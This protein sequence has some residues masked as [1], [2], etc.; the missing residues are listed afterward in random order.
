MSMPRTGLC[1]RPRSRGESKC[2]YDANK[3]KATFDITFDEETELTGYMKLHLW[4]EAD[5]ND[6]M[7]LFVAIQKLDAKGKWLPYNVMGK[8]HPGCPGKLRVS[9]REVDE[10]HPAPQRV[11]AVASLQELAEAQAGRDRAG[12]DRDLSFEPDLARGRAV[13]RGGHGALRAHRLVRALR[14]E[15]HQQGQS[16]HSLGR[17]ERRLGTGVSAGY[18]SDTSAVGVRFAGKPRMRANS[19][20]LKLVMGEAPRPSE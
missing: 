6:D 18:P 15:H 11:P 7:D 2:H 16:R 20:G 5:G 9:L 19:G 8:P 14:L 1:R 13:T 10:K 17:Q 4:V 12:R 3:G